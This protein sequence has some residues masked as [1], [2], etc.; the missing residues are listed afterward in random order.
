M[1]KV[2]IG[3]ISVGLMACGSTRYRLTETF[4]PTMH[5]LII[6]TE[7]TIP[8][9]GVV[10]EREID[11]GLAEL[12]LYASGEKKTNQ[13]TLLINSPGGS[14]DTM[15]ELS[16]AM[17]E[18][19]AR[20]TEVRCVVGS[21]AASAAFMILLHCDTRY[22]FPDSLLLYHPP[23]LSGMFMARSGDLAL[24]ALELAGIDKF[25]YDELLSVIPKR[26]L[27]DTYKLNLFWTGEQLAQITLDRNWIKMVGSIKEEGR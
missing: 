25:I 7:T 12:K 26:L 17:D 3:V 24:S 4:K 8:L 6:D 5:D 19:R 18:I 2:L 23:A 16:K 15:H 20:K 1:K 27:D 13:V 21:M 22:A 10:G 11:E 14:V 9:V